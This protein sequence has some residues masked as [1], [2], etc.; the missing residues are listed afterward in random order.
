MEKVVEIIYKNYRG[1]VSKRK[2]IP[3]KI[4]YGTTKWHKKSGWLLDA[5][6][7]GKKAERS[8]AIKDIQ[9]WKEDPDKKYIS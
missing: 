2:I 6:D 8:F 9:H 7:L 5:F 4:W 3:E 1:E